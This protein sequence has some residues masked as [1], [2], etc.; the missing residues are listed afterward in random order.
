MNNKKM[1][2]VLI[3]S[4]SLLLL[5]AIFWGCQQGTE[6]TGYGDWQISSIYSRTGIDS[7]SDDSYVI[8]GAINTIC[9]Y[10]YRID[11][12]GNIQLIPTNT[13][14]YFTAVAETINST[15]FSTGVD[16]IY[17]G[18][19]FYPSVPGTV[20]ANVALASN[21]V[22]LTISVSVIGEAVVSK[23]RYF[24]AFNDTQLIVL[25]I[26]DNEV[27]VDGDNIWVRATVQNAVGGPIADELV[28]FSSSNH[29][30]G[31]IS[32]SCLFSNSSGVCQTY[33]V[34]GTRTG[35]DTICATDSHGNTDCK[36]IIVSPAVANTGSLAADNYHIF[37]CGIGLYD[38]TDINAY[39][40]DRYWNPVKN[41][42]KVIFKIDDFTNIDSCSGG[43]TLVDGCYSCPHFEPQYSGSNPESA[44][45]FSD[46]VMTIDGVATVKLKAGSLPGVVDVRAIVLDGSGVEFSLPNINISSGEPHYISLSARPVGSSTWEAGDPLNGY[47][48]APLDDAM[49][50]ACTQDSIPLELMAVVSD[51]FHN[52]IPDVSVWFTTSSGVVGGWPG[53]PAIA[54]NTDSTGIARSYW[55]SSDR[56]ELDSC[57]V[58]I[59]AY[60]ADSSVE[61]DL[62]FYLR[63][64]DGTIC[65][66]PCENLAFEYSHAI[67]ETID[68]TGTDSTEISAK[69]TYSGMPMVNFPIYFFASHGWLSTNIDS[70]DGE[71]IA[72]VKY[73][74]I[75]PTDEMTVN[76]ITIITSDYCETTYV[77]VYVRPAAV[78]LNIVLTADDYNP[79]VG[80]QE[81][82][83]YGYIRDPM[84]DP[85]TVPLPIEWYF[86]PDTID[87]G[88]L[89]DYSTY[90]DTLGTFGATFQTSSEAGLV[91]ICAIVASSETVCVSLNI[92]P[93]IVTLIADDYNPVVGG[94][95]V[96]FTGTVRDLY[97]AP[98]TTPQPVIWHFLTPSGGTLPVEMGA[99]DSLSFYTDT[100]GN[101]GGIFTTNTAIGSVM[102]IV[103]VDDI[104][105]DTLYLVIHSG[106]PAEINL[107]VSP[108]V[109]TAGG[110]VPDTIYGCITDEFGNPVEFDGVVDLWLS[111]DPAGDSVCSPCPYG[112]IEPTS[113]VPDSSG[114]FT[115]LF[116]PG[117][118]SGLIWIQAQADSAR[119]AVSIMI[120]PQLARSESLWVENNHIRTCGN[121]PYQTQIVA[122]I[123]DQFGNPVRDLTPVM[124]AIDTFTYMDACT[125]WDDSCLSPC[126]RLVP[127]HPTLGPLHS[128]TLLTVDGMTQVT[129]K[130]GNVSGVVRV[131]AY[132]LDGSGE[133]ATTEMI[134]ISSGNIG[135]LS[136]SARRRSNIDESSGQP[137]LEVPPYTCEYCNWDYNWWSGDPEMSGY[138]P[139]LNLTGAWNM[140]GDTCNGL[141]LQIRISAMDSFGNPIPNASVFLSCD[142]GLIGGFPLGTTDTVALTD[143]FGLAYT[144]W[145]AADPRID[146]TPCLK[147]SAATPT[148]CD[149]LWFYML[150]TLGIPPYDTVQHELIYAIPDTVFGDGL[151]TVDI[152]FRVTRDGN[153]V[154][155]YPVY[156]HADSGSV[157]SPVLT[158][159]VG[160]AKTTYYSALNHH[161]SPPIIT[162]DRIMAIAGVDT[163]YF[164]IFLLPVDP[165]LPYVAY[166][167]LDLEPE[168]IAVGDTTVLTGLILDGMGFPVRLPIPVHFA[169]RVDGAPAPLGMGMISPSYTY[170]SM[171]PDSAGY[172]HSV[173]RS[174][175]EAG[176]LWIVVSAEDVSESLLVHINGGS[177]QN[178]IVVPEDS[179]LEADNRSSI[180]VVAT[181]TDMYGNPVEGATVEFS[182]T[183]GQI[184]PS[185]V[186][187]GADGT[188]TTILTSGTTTGLATITATCED[189][190]GTASV[191]F[192][193]ATV[194]F[195][196]LDVSPNSIVADGASTADVTADV[197]DQYGQPIADGTMVSFICLDT[198]GNP[199]GT[200]DTIGT[201]SDGIANATLIAPTTVGEGW[202]YATAMGH[203]DS[204]KV[205]FIA[206]EIQTLT[207]DAYPDSIPAD[208]VSRST[209]T[210][211]AFDEFGNPVGAGNRIDFTT[212]LG[213]LIFSHSY[214]DNSGVAEVPLESPRETGTAHIT[215]S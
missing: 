150:D 44:M 57:I 47:Y 2:F 175:T 42:T 23:T 105:S 130:A 54:Q 149:S 3:G 131:A 138:A 152:M 197:R 49:W 99:S 174:G 76:T 19:I 109:D 30:L 77:P 145:Y 112:S 101:F 97:G 178:V 64:D 139:Q 146:G 168:N 29:S 159:S 163:V 180:S 107:T 183:L 84:G 33:F 202:V 31:T 12:K 38:Q 182:T 167:L 184:A 137:C 102:V 9:A 14:V 78:D 206:G 203:I 83:L 88:T 179:L 143:S 81:V 106:V 215:A 187:T 191:E 166:I 73:S 117:T 199:I 121:P 116:S 85:L 39:V 129:L 155:N 94:Q 24:T 142:E 169:L 63:Y 181:V 156:L 18:D 53:S 140:D 188:A 136:I 72:S 213:T 25:E 6:P 50:G 65:C 67:P 198:L 61:N 196:L 164:S 103:D 115:A 110:L 56:R 135:I 113:V 214:T 160:Y 35:I 34:V 133:M 186:I 92:V 70:T 100:L 55:F 1:F 195:I 89:V 87:F 185:S 21:T 111:Y 16:T 127:S 40:C 46:T 148:I 37:R 144:Y 165:I 114:C 193:S 172:F 189:R 208:G 68:G 119:G 170:T 79:A 59:R 134:N 154:P 125:V 20:C 28:C 171:N 176:D 4:L 8:P 5:L 96:H 200:I 158:D 118:M 98:I 132:V 104:G 93:G 15:T 74:A 13:Q 75:N 58:Q 108:A 177:P 157:V 192:V 147:V 11:E 212:D 124:F 173:F 207:L 32:D 80:G 27:T 17:N 190:V 36:T 201:T 95:I 91:N 161:M 51:E 48:S 205:E 90:S 71:G 45:V 26:E 43:D 151:S 141:W 7:L 194:H 128:D 122:Y 86:D 153:P 69:L 52:P 66:D 60:S 123:F 209:L 62:F 22:Q 120:Y 126:P 204:A 162:E 82:N 41:G 210:A 10:I 211:Q